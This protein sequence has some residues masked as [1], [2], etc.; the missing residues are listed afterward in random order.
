MPL[1]SKCLYIDFALISDVCTCIHI[2]DGIYDGDCFQVFH[3]CLKFFFGDVAD[4]VAVAVV[5]CC[6][7]CVFVC[8]GAGKLWCVYVCICVWFGLFRL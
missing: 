7:G 6:L 4:F 5:P 2:S 3:S 8:D 1:S